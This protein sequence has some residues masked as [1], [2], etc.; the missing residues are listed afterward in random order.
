M[1]RKCLYRKCF[2]AIASKYFDGNMQLMSLGKII[3]LSAC[4]CGLLASCGD[5][6]AENPQPVY[7]TLSTDESVYDAGTVIELKLG[8]SAMNGQN[9]KSFHIESFDSERGN[10]FV[11][12]S[13]LANPSSR[14]DCS[15]AYRLPFFNTDSLALRFTVNVLDVNGN[16]QNS[17][18]S[19]QVA[20]SDRLLSEL[21]GITLYTSEGENRPNGYSFSRN[22]PIRVSLS[23]SADIDFQTVLDEA[24]NGTLLRKWTTNTNL[25]FVKSNSFNYAKASY[26]NVVSAYKASVGY[27][28]VDNI[29]NDDIIIIGND[30]AP[31]AIVKVVNVFDE[32][33]VVNDRFLINMKLVK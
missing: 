5:L 23:D 16:S 9:L 8:A 17:S 31:L 11:K 2:H 3:L 6:T 20:S 15:I 4:F 14:L 18:T 10:V 24:L 33:G 13:T 29:Q 19:I 28:V 7:A 30:S 25:Y 22:L 1:V 27:H 21:S 12:D 26:L 32:E